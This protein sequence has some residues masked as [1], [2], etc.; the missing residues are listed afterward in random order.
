MVALKSLSAPVDR[1]AGEA[2]AG[3]PGVEVRGTYADLRGTRPPRRP[4]RAALR[5]LGAGPDVMVGLFV[6]RSLEMVVGILGILKAGAAYVPMDTGI[7]TNALEFMLS[8]PGSS[9]C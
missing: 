3:P 9:C 5:G 4:A 8:M 1:T 2:Y 7:P 6:E